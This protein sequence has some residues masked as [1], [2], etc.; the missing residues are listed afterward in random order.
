MSMHRFMHK[1]T[2]WGSEVIGK[3]GFILRGV[4][5]YG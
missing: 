3:P 2:V 5:K 4:Y 1:Y